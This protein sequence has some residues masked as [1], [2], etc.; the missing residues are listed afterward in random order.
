MQ[1]RQ[2]YRAAHSYLFSF[3][4]TDKVYTLSVAGS[5]HEVTLLKDTFQVLFFSLLFFVIFLVAVTASVIYSRYVT[6]P[7]LQ[8]EQCFP[9][10][11]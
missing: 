3:A 1:T 2:V 9:E 11:V 8:L 5:A 6:K 10:N 4:D 7:V